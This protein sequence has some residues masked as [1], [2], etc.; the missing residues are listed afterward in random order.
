[1]RLLIIL[2]KQPLAT[3]NQV[4]ATR[5]AAGLRHLGHEVRLLEVELTDS[6]RIG[7]A[8]REFR[9]ELALLLHA[10]RTGQP[11]LATPE[12]SAIPFLVIL[13]GT[14]LHHDFDSAERGAICGRVLGCAGAI[15]TQNPLTAPL[16]QERF[17]AWRERIYHLPQGVQLG[18][19]PYRLRELHNID[20]QSVLFL[21]P[22]GIRPVKGNLEL[23]QLFDRVVKHRPQTVLA[24]C[25]PP[26]DPEYA[27]RFQKALTERPWARYLGAIPPAA[28]PAAL[29][30]ADVVLNH[31]LSE[32]LPNALIEASVLG[33]PILAKAIEGNAAVV[34]PGENGYLYSTD[35]EFCTLAL[36]L[37]DQPTLRCRL[38]QPRPERYAVSLEAEALNRIAQEV[39]HLTMKPDS[40]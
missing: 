39:L 19:E 17:P 13:T 8:L 15:L 18:T 11:W 7:Q 1:M 14:D 27:A 26:L 25:G 33:V 38:R 31:S 32:G 22:A 40:R 2:P 9:P 16:L 34:T 28:M 29:R 4:T 3:G 35:E 37:I 10:W 21:H 24:F 20:P 30:A 23:L 36:Q 5:Y 12:S 6:D